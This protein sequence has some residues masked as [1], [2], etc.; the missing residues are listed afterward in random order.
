M[1]SKINRGRMEFNDENYEK[2]LLY[3]DAVD[4][5]DSSRGDDTDLL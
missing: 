3:F 5:D 1:D 2:A 4:E